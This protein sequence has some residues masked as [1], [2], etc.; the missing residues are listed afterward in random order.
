MSSRDRAPA[1]A[2]VISTVAGL[3]IGAVGGLSARG[4]SGLHHTDLETTMRLIALT[5]LVMIAFAANSIFG[6]WAIGGGHM[7]ATGFGL[8][9]LASGAAML[10]LLCLVQGQRLAE[11]WRRVA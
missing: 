1:L 10:G 6:R 11:D 2:A 7:D 5:C 4:L 9:R 8:L 3:D